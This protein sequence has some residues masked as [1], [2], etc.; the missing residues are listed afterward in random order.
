MKRQRMAQC[1]PCYQRNTKIEEIRHCDESCWLRISLL[2]RQE[3]NPNLDKQK[4]TLTV[5]L[6]QRA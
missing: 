3:H 5:S 4:E 6:E 2:S 1:T